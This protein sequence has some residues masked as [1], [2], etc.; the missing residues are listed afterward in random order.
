MQ[1]LYSFLLVLIL[2]KW[3]KKYYKN[4]NK[5]QHLINNIWFNNILKHFKKDA[6]LYEYQIL[7][8]FLIKIVLIWSNGRKNNKK[9]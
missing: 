6:I 5:K 9:I 1:C 4:L 7:I 8:G 3:S 2:L